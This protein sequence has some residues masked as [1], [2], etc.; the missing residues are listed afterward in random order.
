MNPMEEQMR[1]YIIPSLAAAGLL[2]MNSLAAADTRDFELVNSTRFPFTSTYFATKS[3]N[4]WKRTRG[5]GLAA[6]SSEDITF[7]DSGDCVVKMKIDWNGTNSQWING[8]DLCSVSK[9]EV[10]EESDGRLTAFSR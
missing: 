2:S 4:V 9:I 1:K 7:D 3:I 10:V 8:F 6:H 5:Y